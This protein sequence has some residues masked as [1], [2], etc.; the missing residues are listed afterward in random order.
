M[1]SWLP[2]SSRSQS[3]KESSHISHG[4]FSCRYVLRHNNYPLDREPRNLS[5][6]LDS[7]DAQGNLQDPYT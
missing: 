1:I 6:E 2:A 5:R 4:L 7:P 3:P